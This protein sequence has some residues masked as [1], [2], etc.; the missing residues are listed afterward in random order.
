MSEQITFNDLSPKKKLEHIWAYYRFPIIAVIFGT[1]LLISLVST[2]T[3]KKESV[4]DV[5]MVDSNANAHS[6]A[7]AFDDFLESCGI[8]PYEG[9][10]T[11]NTNISFYN[12]DEL[13]LLSETERNQA[14]LDNYD[15]QQILFTL[16]AAGE[17]DVFFGKGEIFLAYAEEGMF[18]DLS[19]ILSPELLARYENQLIYTVENGV[20][21]P[22]A[23]ALKA[24]PWL[25]ENGYY[26]EC[27][28]AILYLSDNPEIAARFAE[29][30]LNQ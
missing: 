29:Y 16:M 11:L 12:E 30:L 25:A 19:A 26:T 4:L 27:Y 1:I 22:C 2:L 24:D 9:A 18:A 28:F 6:E 5:I 17:G 14:V 10:V 8:E 13:A 23:I 7:A 21:Y 3:G 20:R 15:K